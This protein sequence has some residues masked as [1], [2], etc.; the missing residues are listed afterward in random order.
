MHTNRNHSTQTDCL[1]REVE[2]SVIGSDTVFTSPYGERK[3]IYCDYTASGRS[4]KFIEDY[5]QQEV[6]P[7]YGNTH[8]TTSITSRQMTKFRHEAK[9]VIR[10]CVN[11]SDEDAVIF[12]G[13]GSTGAIHKLV[14]ALELE[15]DKAQRTAVLVGPFEHHSNILPWKETGATVIRIKRTSKGLLDMNDL[16]AQLEFCSV[17]FTDVIGCFSA[18]SNVTGILTDTNAVSALLHHY[19]ALA[20]WDYATAAPYVNIDMN[21]KC[22][23]CDC[24]CSKDAVF[25]SVHKF[26]GGPG[27]PGLLIAKKHLFQ[28]KVPAG[29]GGGTVH[30][31]SRNMHHY[32]SDIEA[33]EEGGTP[34]IIE[35]IRA[36]LVFQL[37]QKIGPHYIERREAELTRR[38]FERWSKN[39]NLIILGDSEADR[40]PIFSFLVRHPLTGKALHHNFIA[41]LL[42]DLYGIQARGG[43]A[44]AGPYAHDLLGIS[45]ESARK[46]YEIVREDRF[47]VHNEKPSEIIR[48][49]FARLNL[50]FFVSD[51]EI[52]YILCAV[53]A[54][55]TYGWKLLPQYEFDPF[56]G[57]WKHRALDSLPKCGAGFKSL[58]DIVYNSNG[59]FVPGPT[60]GVKHNSTRSLTDYF[61]EAQHVLDQSLHHEISY[62]ALSDSPLVL[63]S[64]N[65]DMK[66]FLEPREAM[67]CLL[68]MSSFSQHHSDIYL[69]YEDGV[70][71]S[72]EEVILETSE[73]ESSP[74]SETY[75]SLRSFR[76]EEE[77]LWTDDDDDEARSDDSCVEDCT[78]TDAV[79]PNEEQL[80]DS[81]SGYDDFYQGSDMIKS[82][83]TCRKRY[84]SSDG[85]VYSSGS[86]EHVYENG[87]RSMFKIN[88][89]FPYVET[90]FRP[91]L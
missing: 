76:E 22:E 68:E 52:D 49:G 83:N 9:E 63:G 3:V 91:S 81:D 30:Y 71:V 66:W 61:L 80:S 32:V 78:F 54:V 8:T 74:V 72:N 38:A 79:V 15:G 64:G 36:G 51:E 67:V 60:H 34:A 44:C 13:S 5:I 85:A 73:E 58:L 69:V 26:L 1:L 37:K 20:C 59:Q 55:A 35:S 12:A 7:L 11:A 62:K 28:N 16:K 39:E 50:P 48:P 17:N 65:E 31:V 10:D 6:S 4:L 14:H 88:E 27:S 87:L 75:S 89:R 57:L 86:P 42:N 90:A 2:R 40:L 82:K 45:E 25:I 70:E 29:A 18:A 23:T 46:F 53:D 41:A 19:G 33:R 24:D 56:T 43:C 77:R 21:P 84:L 47:D